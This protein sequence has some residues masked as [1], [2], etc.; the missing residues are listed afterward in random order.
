MANSVLYNI[1]HKFARVVLQK[2]LFSGALVRCLMQ[3]YVTEC[4]LM[5]N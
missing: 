2:F 5:R 4:D 3:A 1:V